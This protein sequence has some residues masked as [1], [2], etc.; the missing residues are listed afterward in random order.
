MVDNQTIDAYHNCS[1]CH[2]EYHV[3]VTYDDEGN[4]VAC[5]PID[6]ER[7]IRVLHA[8]DQ[9]VIVCAQHQGI[10]VAA[11]LAEHY[12]QTGGHDH[13]HDD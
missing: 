8:A 10:E 2:R 6:T 3:Q 9:L 12:F 13:E 7:E 11:A 5:I 1:V 4:I